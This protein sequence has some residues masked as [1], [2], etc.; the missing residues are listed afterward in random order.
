[1]ALQTDGKI[2]VVGHAVNA[3]GDADF[4]LARYTPSGRLDRSFSG[5]GKVMTGFQSGSRDVA[6][7][8]ALQADGKMVVAGT[9]NGH[10]ALARYLPSGALDTTFSGDG[11]VTTNMHGSATD[12]AFAV[13]LH[14]D[15]TILVVGSAHRDFALARYTPN[16]ALDPTFGRQQDDAPGTVTTNIYDVSPELDSDDRA[17]TVV[18]QS[19]GNIVVGGVAWDDDVGLASFTLARYTTTGLLDQTFNGAGITITDFC[20]DGESGGPVRALTLQ[21]DGKMVAAGSSGYHG[22]FLDVALARYTPD[23]ILDP[24]FGGQGRDYAGTVTTSFG[25]GGDYFS[26]ARA[27]ALQPDGKLVVAGWAEVEVFE[28]YTS[29]VL[30]RYTATGRLDTTFGKGGQILTAFGSGNNE[31]WGMAL[32]PRDGRVVLAGA[33][34]ASGNADFALARYHAHTCG[35]VVVTRIGTNDHDT[36]LGT[37]G[38]DVIFG[39]GGNDIIDGLG[40]NDVL[41]GGSGDDTLR[42]G[43]G[44]D[45]C[46]G[47]QGLRDTATACET[48]TGVP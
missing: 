2:V 46:H 18:L 7:A 47:G 10:V 31:A 34:T 32:Q 12:G 43:A 8:V 29:F 22:S 36:L 9:S 23:G 42:G 6:Y 27:L 28:T 1:V 35:G 38:R 15:G 3:Q 39:F 20:C 37:A 25:R 44:T 48:V 40:G 26:A 41:C 16:G 45:T 14:P 13:I 30:A 19:D 24:T 11:K 5:D 21:P 17:Y 33:T 4:A